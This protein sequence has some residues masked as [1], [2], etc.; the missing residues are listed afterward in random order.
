MQVFA[1]I[2]RSTK[3]FS[4]LALLCA[5]VASTAAAQSPTPSPADL[6]RWSREAASVT[7]TRDDWGIPH[8]SGKTDTDAVFG[9]LYAQAEDD[10]NRVETNYFNALGR[11][12]ETEGEGAIYRDLRM[13]LINNPDSLKAIYSRSPHWLQSVMNAWADGLNYY[14]YEHPQ[15]KPKVIAR[16][17]PWMPLAFSDGSNAIRTAARTALPSPLRT[18]FRITRSFSSIRTRRFSSGPRCR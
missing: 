6:A 1:A 17:E 8:I 13:R 10:F 11:A 2:L 18:H 5:A 4:K 7:I 16:F 9:L 15:V 14:L 3:A 12:A